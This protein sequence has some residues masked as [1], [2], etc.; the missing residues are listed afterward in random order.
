MRP[1]R[2]MRQVSI[3]AVILAAACL[4]PLCSCAQG[5]EPAA[6]GQAPAE[7]QVSTKVEVLDEPAEKDAES[8][9][10]QDA[11][12]EVP[13]DVEPE[14]EPEEPA[15]DATAP[16]STQTADSGVTVTAPDGFLETSA[17]KDV[18]REIAA[19]TESGYHVGVVMRDL[20]TG[21]SITYNTDERLYPASSIKATFCAM[22]CEN[23]GG[24]G[25]SA[26]TMEQCLVYSSNEAFE[27]LINTYGLY[28]HAAWLQANGAPEAASDADYWYYPDIS[29]GELAATWQEIYRYGTS[30]EA[31]SSELTGYLSRTE[32]SPI[33]ELLRGDYEVWSKPGWFPD[34]G[35]LVAT[36]DAGIV[37]SDC[38]AYEMVI[39]TTMS[40]NLDGLLP[41]IDALNVAH[42]TMCGGATES[43]L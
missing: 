30:G 18:E 25:S 19:L 1:M 21:N 3:F 2:P 24:P 28:A 7:E 40:S 22:V 31:G 13:Q 42:G 5:Q 9:A 12:S 4:L 11:E 37:F 26:A 36:N 16:V 8:E 14:P 15:F 39:M 27:T 20:A 32:S 23:N 43:L 10:A 29:A 17:F 35:N 33:G 41:L 34:N 38:G 6:N